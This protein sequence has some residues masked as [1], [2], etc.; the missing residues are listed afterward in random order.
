[1]NGVL[2]RTSFQ[3]LEPGTDSLGYSSRSL[4]I[5]VFFFPIPVYCLHVCHLYHYIDWTYIL[6]YTTC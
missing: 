2:I 3:L 4:S 6:P 5:D 1:M